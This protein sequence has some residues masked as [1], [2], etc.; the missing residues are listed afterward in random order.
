MKKTSK[1]ISLRKKRFEKK[2]KKVTRNNKY[3]LLFVGVPMIICSTLAIDNY[4][5]RLKLE[6]KGIEYNPYVNVDFNY[7]NEQSKEYQYKD[8]KE[9]YS[10]RD[11]IKNY[12]DSK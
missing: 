6:K 2:C 3:L 8:I 7:I 1:V 10:Y 11:K 4:F 5:V 12:M 9:Y